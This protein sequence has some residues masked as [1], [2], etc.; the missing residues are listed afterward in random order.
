MP[1]WKSTHMVR[2]LYMHENSR[3]VFMVLEDTVLGLQI[4]VLKIENY[5]GYLII[6]FNIGVYVIKHEYV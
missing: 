2:A 3:L 4:E 6:E 1:V 5:K